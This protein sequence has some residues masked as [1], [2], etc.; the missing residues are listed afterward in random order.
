MATIYELQAGSDA[1]IFA[2]PYRTGLRRKAVRLPDGAIVEE[3]LPDQRYDAPAHPEGALG[4]GAGGVPATIHHANL[5]LITGYVPL[6]GVFLLPSGDVAAVYGA[7]AIP[8]DA[9]IATTL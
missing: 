7:E 2:V 9:G 1:G 8:I 6:A 5:G 3:P 4:I